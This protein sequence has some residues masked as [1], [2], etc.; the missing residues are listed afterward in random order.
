[1]A[2]AAG[3]ERP[4]GTT[5]AL[6]LASNLPDLDVVLLARSEASYLLF[7]RGLTHSLLGL[8]VLPPLLALGLWWGLRRTRFG[9]LCLV[10]WAGAALHVAYDL[11]TP[12]G[13]ILLYPFSLDRYALD[14]LF[15]VDFVTWGVPVTAVVAA[16]RRPARSRAA[17]AL[18]LVGIALYAGF[19]G[20]VHRAVVGATVNAE[21]QAGQ[22]IGEVQAF[23]QLGAPWRWQ[24]LAVAPLTVAAPW[25]SRYGVTGLPPEGR[26]ED[27]IPRGFDDPWA[28]RAFA[29]ADGQAYLWWA[30]VPLARV[31]ARDERVVV[32]LADLRFSRTIVPTTETWGPFSVRFTFDRASGTLREI[33]W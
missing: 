7:H 32:T 15:I 3:T 22:P 17:A 2:R 18:F 26:L 29:T 13:T 27:R 28:R 8:L 14:W 16:W 6:V 20:L 33:Q 9:W 10:C 1:L 24:G 12:W 5:L 25:I 4:R 23:P 11:V 31:V 30:R 21:R 19:S